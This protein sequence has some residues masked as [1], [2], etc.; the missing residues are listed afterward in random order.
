M[1]LRRKSWP[2]A[3]RDSFERQPLIETREVAEKE[4]EVEDR[5]RYVILV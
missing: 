5:E 1:Y 4:S 3:P 2:Q